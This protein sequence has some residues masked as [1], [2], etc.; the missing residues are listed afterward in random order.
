[1]VRD[2]VVYPDKRINVLSPDLRVFDEN[3]H[4]VIR[5][6]KDTMKE[7][8]TDAMA[9][10]QIAIPM[11]IIV[12]KKEDGSYLEII[13][14]RIIGKEGL[15]DSEESTLYFQDTKQNIKRYEKIKLIFQDTDAKQQSL[16]ANGELAITLQRKIDYV[17]GAT[18]AN[19]TK[20]D[21]RK[22]FEKQLSAN[23]MDGSFESCPTVFM[24]DYFLSVIQ[25]IFFFIVIAN[26]IGLFLSD[27][28][29][30]TITTYSSY[31]ILAMLAILVGYFFVA[32]Y[33]SKI[34]SSC[35]SCQ[36]G[37]IIGTTVKYLLAIGILYWVTQYLI[38]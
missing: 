6:L 1:M 30:S 4:S 14:P 13:N 25:K 29:F 35:T 17:Y 19:R 9:A 10:I 27:A 28:T 34:Y 18:L 38:A 33:E 3:M 37:N 16:D 32:Y 2:I 36:V 22:D 24:R 31:S 5:D 20:D 26:I 15:I 21:G 23:G 12:I 8:N 11:S 7:H